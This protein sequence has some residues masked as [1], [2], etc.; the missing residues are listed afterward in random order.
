MADE[1]LDDEVRT[2]CCGALVAMD[3]ANDAWLCDSCGGAID[4]IVLHDDIVAVPAMMAT[5]EA[6]V[7]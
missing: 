7:S 5:N 6:P 3:I 4:L 1:E 2:E